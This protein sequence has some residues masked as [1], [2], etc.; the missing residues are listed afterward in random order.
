MMRFLAPVF[1]KLFKPVPPM[2]ILASVDDPIANDVAA[3]VAEHQR[4]ALLER[5]T[6]ERRLR[7]TMNDLFNRMGKGDAPHG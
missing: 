2:D 6:Y 1:R 5:E 3:V 4:V 7:E